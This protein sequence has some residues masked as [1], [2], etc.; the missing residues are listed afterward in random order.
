[1]IVAIRLN[2]TVDQRGEFLLHLEHVV[3]FLERPAP[4]GAKVVDA[5]DPF[6]MHGFGFELHVFAAIALDLDDQVQGIVGAAPVVDVDDEIR[7]V[8][9]RRRSVLVR[10]FKAKALILNVGEDARVVL[11]GACKLGLPIAVAYD[12]VDVA[13][14]RIWSY[15][16]LCL[17]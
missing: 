7:Q 11:G 16:G 8:E 1:M 14:G 12:V 4:I 3:E 5:P 10:N 13:F 15:R 6:L 2:R 17:S 9:T